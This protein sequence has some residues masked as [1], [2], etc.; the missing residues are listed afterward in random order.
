MFTIDPRDCRRWGS[1][2]LQSAKGLTT[3]S[4]RMARKSSTRELVDG[5]VRRVPAGVVDQAVESAVP[6]ERLGE[7]RLTVLV[8]RHVAADEGRGARPGGRDTL[9]N[10]GPEVRLEPTEHNVGARLGEDID[11]SFADALGATGDDRYLV[12]DSAR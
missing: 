12:S 7:E 1:A 2:A 4:S 10:G 6:R 8:P 3:F 5:A 11:T 9:G